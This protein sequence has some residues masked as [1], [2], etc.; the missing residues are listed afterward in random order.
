MST[1]ELNLHSIIIFNNDFS[2][3]FV[4]ESLFEHTEKHTDIHTQFVGKNGI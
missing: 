3:F 4:S 2:N 1:K